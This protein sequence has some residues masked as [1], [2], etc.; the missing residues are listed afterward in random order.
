MDT[1]SAPLAIR[2]R[3]NKRISATTP[4]RAEY[5][6]AQA[7]R[8][9]IAPPSHARL[10][11]VTRAGITQNW[12]GRVRRGA[13]DLPRHRRPLERGA[14]AGHLAVLLPA[15]AILFDA[16]SGTTVLRRLQTAGIPLERIHH[17]F[18]T[19]RHFDHVGGLAP[20]L[21]S[22]A[23]SRKPTYRPRPSWNCKGAGGTVGPHDPRRRG[24]AR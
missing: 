23:S 4:R 14:G 1:S 16:S 21:I 22:M 6:T 18:V 3:A 2:L 17:L 12:T 8:Y 11:L 20:L 19:H 9:Y 15:E 7:G 24:M 5:T 10:Y 13:R